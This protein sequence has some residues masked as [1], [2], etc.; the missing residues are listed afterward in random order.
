MWRNDP[1]RTPA[2][3]TSIAMTALDSLRSGTILQGRYE[4]VAAVGA[5]GFGVV[6]K[7][8]QLATK[9][10]VAVKFMHPIAGETEVR[11]ETRTARFRREMDL[12]AKLQHPNIVAL[13]D[14]G[15][16]DDGQLFVVFQFASGK[17]LDQLLL[18][19]GPLSPREAQYLMSQVLDALSCAHN[20]GV[21]H[22]DLKPANI[23]IVSTGTRRNALVLDFGIGA[24]ANDVDDPT[25]HKLTAQHEWVGTPYY[26]A[27]EQIRGCA[28]T[29]QSDIYSWG[30]VYLECLAGTRVIAGNATAA[31]MYH[32]G[33]DPI[34]IPPRLRRHHL[35]RLLERAVLKDVVDRTV[36][37]AALLAELDRC[38]VA[39]LD[40]AIAGHPSAGASQGDP[41]DVDASAGAGPRLQS[42]ADAA[43]P[44]RPSSAQRR[45]VDGERRQITVMCCS[46]APPPGLELDDLDQ[47]MHVQHELCAEV[48]QRF[49]GHLIGGLGHQAMIGFGYP[50]ASEDDAIR[51]ARAALAVR[52]A[53]TERNAK[54]RGNGRVAIKI[55]LHT[56]MI[57]YNADNLAQSASGQFFGMIPMTASQLSAKA[58]INT[59]VASPAVAQ[60]LRSHIVMTALGAHLIDGDSQS[61]ELFQVDSARPIMTSGETQSGDA[62]LPL[63]GR[64]RELAFLVERWSN[65][66]DGD[67]QS[68][69]VLG[70]AGLGKSRLVTELRRRITAHQHTW[71][72]AHC[73]HETRNS[74]LHPIIELVERLLNLGDSEPAARLHRIESALVELG[75]RLSE[76]VPLIAGL[77]S[78]PVGDRYPVGDLSPSRRRDLTLSTI[79]S[80]VLELSEHAPLV[81]F[82]EDLHW[83]DQ[84]SL[85]WLARLVAAIP[86]GRVLAMFSARPELTQPWP[87]STM[88]QIQLPRLARPE[89]EQ[90]VFA[91]TGGKLLPREV[92]EQIVARTDGVPLFVEELTRVVVESGALTPRADRYELTG[93]LVDVEIP[94]TLRALLM[95]RLDRL[96][97]AKQTAQLAAALGREFDVAL[98]SAVGSLT[99]AALQEDLDRLA[100][101][102]IVHHRRRL[103]NPTWVFRHALTRDIAYESMPR[104][105]QQRVHAR[106]AEVL[107]AQFSELTD[108][109]PD[110]LAMH[111]A[112]ADQKPQAIR[113]ARQ[114]ARAALVG[115]AY[116]HAIRHG[117][118]ALGWLAAVSDA[119]TAMAISTSTATLEF[120]HVATELDLRV[121]LSVPLM[122]T[123]GFAS[124]EVETNYLRVL[125]LGE[126]VGDSAANSLFP[127][128]CGL[129][130]FRTVSGDCKAAEAAAERLARLGDRIRD[131]SIQL[132]AMT[133]HGT[134]VMMQGRREEAKRSFEAALA[135]Y[136]RARHSSL[137]TVLGQDAGAMCV[138]FLTWIHAHDHDSTAAEAHAAA[139][140]EMC[141]SLRQPSTRAFVETVLGTWRCLRGDFGA[142]EQH[143]NAVIQLAAEQG[144]LHWNAQATIIRGWAISGLGR[145]AEGAGLA[146]AGIDALLGIGS[147]AAMTFYWAAL[148]EAHIAA[149]HVDH[150][151]AALDEARRYMAQSGERIY[152][153][154]IALLEAKIAIIGGD[155]AAASAANATAITVAQL[156]GNERLTSLANELRLQLGVA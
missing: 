132:A 83:A 110:L 73:T 77:L 3:V 21:V 81:I 138:S 41:R 48:A 56:G 92:I 35:G 142:A 25:Y 140:L 152:E 122:M 84:T 17:S 141:D 59:I 147:K 86:S 120:D 31:L 71:L 131:S 144:M 5:G 75:I 105:V 60:A 124:K 108:A 103:R 135:L 121:T 65:A 113:Y 49:R 12:C 88:H 85:D 67:G 40:R 11:R 114:A 95:S 70:E 89:I 23:M 134:A 133:A 155:P 47:L 33:P 123:Q 146:R 72:E 137:A 79:I 20:L 145:A 45:L 64:A 30:L 61:F 13:V 58:A 44:Q 39:D 148:A 26:T 115:S 24:M 139:A 112:A 151:A 9:Q 97:R 87:S 42:S 32:I 1:L 62:S 19:D 149:G 154:G 128:L 118:E 80:L 16:T 2:A 34:P 69:L 15:E 153:A 93:L 38:E 94:A 7:A 90:L 4:L 10:P 57:A 102:D 74:E 109:R 111:H 143:A 101:A 107:E 106:I 53:V 117:R 78:V 50:A 126:L 29:P 54:L 66:I 43:T 104:R 63:F 22:R 96:G 28:P 18:D 127:A 27:P 116:A 98:L 129:W 36:S 68:V 51:A 156:Q 150:A 100:E 8:I 125:E 91:V 130:T 37:A 136:D 6:Y 99:P 55:G 119:R 76:V 52:A 14:S 82:M 46:L